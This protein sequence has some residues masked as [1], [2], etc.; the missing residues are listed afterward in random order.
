VVLVAA[1]MLLF[2]AG[3]LAGWLRI[4][5]PL[6]GPPS[7]LHLA[8]GTLFG[9]GMVLAGGCVVGSLYKAGAGSL[10]SALAV[11]GIVAGSALYAEMH[12]AWTAVAKQWT[13]AREITLPQWLGID[14]AWLI[15]PSLT[16][17]LIWLRRRRKKRWWEC[18]A[19]A[20]GYLQPWKAALLLALIGALSALA[21]GM[22]LGI[23]TGYTK[24]AGYLERLLFPVHFADLALFAGATLDF[25]HPWYSEVLR[26]GPGPQLDAI[27]AIQWPLLAGLVLGS[28]ASARSLREWRLQWRVPA[29]QY[30][31]VLAGGV[32]MGVAA[33]LAAGCTIWHLW[34][35]M[36]ILALPSLLFVAGLFPGAWLGGV[37]FSRYVIGSDPLPR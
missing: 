25:S 23:T 9:L 36:A 21:V 15:F 3:R 4:P 7:V 30:L 20:D 12:P 33:R 2:E 1:G 37:I 22:P 14:P 10:P 18:T 17:G 24:L 11:A 31:S 13:L 34:G 8:G 5:F 6:L 29:R 27:A 16:V 32:L 35:G 28:A 19:F 26:G